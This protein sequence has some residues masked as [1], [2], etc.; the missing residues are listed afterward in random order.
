MTMAGVG[1]LIRPANTWEGV[2]RASQ[3]SLARSGARSG[4]QQTA[5]IVGKALRSLP[6]PTSSA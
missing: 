5:E 1:V 2:S 4:N 3:Q 6:T